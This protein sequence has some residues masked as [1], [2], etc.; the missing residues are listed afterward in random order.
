MDR[1]ERDREDLF[2]LRYH[3]TPATEIDVSG[4]YALT[5]DHDVV[6]CASTDRP[7]DLELTQRAL[8]SI[9]LGGVRPAEMVRSGALTERTPGAL[10]RARLM[11]STRLPPW[12]A[13]GF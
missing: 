5:A 9:Y 11:F 13:T 12:N 3:G 8:A 10:E 6:E 1:G 7:A 2:E 4:R